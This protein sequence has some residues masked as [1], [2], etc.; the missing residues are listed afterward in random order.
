MHND[1]LRD[2]RYNQQICP[3]TGYLAFK[4]RMPILLS[5]RQ[6]S[7]K[8]PKIGKLGHRPAYAEATGRQ[9]ACIPS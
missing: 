6:F 2:L 9:V 1:I 3:A 8:W 7:Q 4:Y 5:S